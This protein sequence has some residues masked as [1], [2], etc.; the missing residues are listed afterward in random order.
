M[1]TLFITLLIFLYHAPLFAQKPFKLVYFDNYPPFSWLENNQMKGM[2]I[3]LTTA[4][5]EKEM[6]IPTQHEGYPW[7]RAQK[8]VANKQADAFVTIP[9]PERRKYTLVSDRPVIMTTATVFVSA[10]NRRMLELQ[11]IRNFRDLADFTNVQYIGNGW[12]KENYGQLEIKWVPTMDKALHLI[13]RNRYDI[14]T[15]TSSVVRYN[16]KRLG[17]EK[18]IVELPVTLRKEGFYL[19]ISKTSPHASILPEYNKAF[20]KL[21]NSGALNKII[22]QYK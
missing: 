2:L 11:R 17:Y 10:K 8:M 3:D 6:G 21:E 16:I 1:K 18:G 13:Y 15:D 4:V 12:A 9:T 19:C 20:Q 22:T 5:I 14:F 7:G